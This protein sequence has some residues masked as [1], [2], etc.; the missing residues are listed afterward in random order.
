VAQYQNDNVHSTLGGTGEIICNKVRLIAEPA[1]PTDATMCSAP[2]PE[3]T[4]SLM[5]EDAAMFV[6]NCH[7]GPSGDSK[8][9]LR[10]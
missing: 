4:L 3:C 5:M 6:P 10:M 1:P 8:L 9:P 2:D 7:S